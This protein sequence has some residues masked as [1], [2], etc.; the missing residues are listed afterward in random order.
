MPLPMPGKKE[1]KTD[2]ISRCMSN[3][4]SKKDFEDNKQR[5]AVCYTQWESAKK[6]AKGSIEIGEDEFLI[7]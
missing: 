7:D 5:V 2:F 1:K 3:E 4:T 6:K